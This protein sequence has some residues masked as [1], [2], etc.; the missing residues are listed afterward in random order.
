MPYRV[1]NEIINYILSFRQP[2]SLVEECMTPLHK[3]YHRDNGF[4]HHVFKD[5]YFYY[6]W[7]FRR[8]PALQRCTKVMPRARSM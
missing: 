7:F 8:P 4:N 5:W 3:M 1:P 6:M 2:H